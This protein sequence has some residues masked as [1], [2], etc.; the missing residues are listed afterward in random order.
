MNIIPVIGWCKSDASAALSLCRWIMH[1]GG[2]ENNDIVL[3]ATP[4]DWASPKGEELKQFVAD[5]PGF[6]VIETMEPIPAGWPIGPNRMMSEALDYSEQ[7]ASPMLWLEPDAVPLR[8]GW[9]QDIE[10]EYERAGTVFMGDWIPGKRSSKGHMSGIGV[11]GP[12][13]RSY[14]PELARTTTEPFDIASGKGVS[15]SFKQSQLIQHLPI[16]RSHRHD[17]STVLL[18]P[19]LAIFHPD[20]D[21]VLIAA[22]AARSQSDAPITQA[23]AEPE[24]ATP[25]RYYETA[26]AAHPI[27]VKH[28]RMEINIQF[29]SYGVVASALAGVLATDDVLVQQFLPQRREVREITEDEYYSLLKKKRTWTAESRGFG[30]SQQAPVVQPIPAQVA[31]RA[32]SNPSS[33]GDDTHAGNDVR[34]STGSVNVRR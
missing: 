6:T 22:R 31:V 1:L 23:V 3:M 28:G 27:K 29:Q 19:K 17:F 14:A 5:S 13:W 33:S 34:I 2:C 30:A 10:E 16:D 7:R 12:E 9:L 26:N 25:M 24:A 21:G 20:K 15:K 11:Y 4:D 18:P 8:K 32:G